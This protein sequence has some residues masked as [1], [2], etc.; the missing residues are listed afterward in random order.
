M[1]FIMS[2]NYFLRNVPPILDETI[3]IQEKLKIAVNNTGNYLYERAVLNQIVDIEIIDALDSYIEPD[4]TLILSM[5][6]FISPFTDLG[7]LAIEIE[8]KK[9]SKIIMIGAGA[10]AYD[11][12]EN[13]NLTRGTN[14]FLSLISERSMSI[15]VRGYYT[16]EILNDLGYKNIDVIGCPSIFMECTPHLQVVSANK[17]ESHFSTIFNFTPAGYFRDKISELIAFGVMNCNAFVAQS[18]TD[19]FGLFEK[20]PDYEKNL[21]FFFSYY[22]NPKILSSDAKQWF[23]LNS[24]WFFDFI[25][26]NKFASDFDFSIGSRFHGNILSILNGKPAL[27][28][29]FDVRTRELCEYLNLPFMLLKDFDSNIPIAHLYDY[30]DFNFFNSTYSLK[31]NNYS[32]F[33]IKNGLKS[34]LKSF[35]IINSFAKKDSITSRS[36]SVLIEDAILRNCLGP[37]LLNEFRLR[38]SLGN[39]PLLQGP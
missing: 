31:Y 22:S 24:H 9:F 29:T 10:Q 13:I 28:L 7:I 2:K 21:D 35:P 30:A 32:N 23:L 33:L 37:D 12:F 11:Y 19:L 34:R 36:I 8:E 17:F 1:G 25:N 18:E 27:N 39:P 16:A 6:N 38:L 20:S 3:S 4:S 14:N 26:W 5:S 15:G